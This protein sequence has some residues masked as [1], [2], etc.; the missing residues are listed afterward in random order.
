[1]AT[2]TVDLRQTGKTVAMTVDIKLEQKIYNQI[3]EELQP[4]LIR[5]QGE[6][7]LAT[8]Q[9]QPHTLGSAMRRFAEQDK[10]LPRGTSKRKVT[11]A[12]AGRPWAPD[13]RVS[14][15]AELLP[16]LGYER[17]Y[18]RI[19]FE[20]SW[21]DPENLNPAITL[22][23][24]FL[25]GKTAQKSGYIRYPGVDYEVAATNYVGIAGVGLDAAEYSAT[26][27]AVANKLGIFG[28][29][30]ATRLSDIENVAK[31]IFMIQVPPIYKGPWLAG[32]GSTVRG[33][34]E[35]KSIE[36]FL[37]TQADGKRGTYIIM[38]DG[39]VRFVSAGIA[40]DVFK[41]L[42]RI[43]GRKDELNLNAVSKLVPR[44]DDQPELKAQASPPPTTKQAPTA[45]PAAPA[46]A[47]D[48]RVMTND[49]KAI[50]LAYHNCLDATRKPP[51]KPDDLAPYLKDDPKVLN[52][53]RAGQ[54]VVL[55][56]ST[57]QGMVNG[58]SNTILAYEKDAPTKGGVVAMA[59]GVVKTM[60]AQEFQAAPKAPGK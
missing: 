54:Y 10:Q 14:W 12:R 32:G 52:A 25:E 48:R 59:D 13:Q 1:V 3:F 37:S 58:T 15:M 31:T 26:D 50:V 51:G 7:E 23:P 43:K 27:P 34:P 5:A 40:D 22:I 42:C 45:P 56:N 39:S 36:P 60:T 6:L 9:P 24:H 35:T 44:P 17:V 28:Y 2:F 11:A 29:D 4:Y 30:R 41:D 18:K 16:Y 21:R 38:A 8:N 46:P 33:V 20:K 57:I 55:W 47:L 19:N 49:L 53:L